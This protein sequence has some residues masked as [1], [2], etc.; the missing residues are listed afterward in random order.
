MRGIYFSVF[1]DAHLLF[2]IHNNKL[3]P[4]EIQVCNIVHENEGYIIKWVLIE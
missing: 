4:Y 1:Y 2:S 3:N